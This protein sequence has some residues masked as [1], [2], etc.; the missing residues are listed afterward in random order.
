MRYG[1]QTVSRQLDTV[2]QALYGISTNRWRARSWL[3][4]A[5]EQAA[6]KDLKSKEATKSMS[7]SARKI[8]AASELV[9]VGVGGGVGG[10]SRV[11]GED[12]A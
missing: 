5:A 3:H 9:A 6:Y 8:R 2:L 4:E 1:A 12:A 10:G 11:S 7:K